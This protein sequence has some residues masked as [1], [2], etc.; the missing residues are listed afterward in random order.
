M[1]VLVSGGRSYDNRDVVYTTLD[2]I[3]KRHKIEQLIHGG[4][5]GADELAAE[6]AVSRNIS[7]ACFP[8]NWYKY[9]KGAGSIRNK[10]MLDEG[11]PDIVVAFPGGK[12]TAN[13]I[14]L[15]EAAGVKVLKIT[16]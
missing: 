5:R 3:L 16:H 9:G 1:R 7:V 6:W 4:A 11:H 15:S 2:T 14:K 10:Q 12:G 13:M 8:A